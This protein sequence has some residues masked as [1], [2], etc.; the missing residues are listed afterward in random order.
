M[1]KTPLTTRRHFTYRVGWIW[2]CIKRPHSKRIFVKNIEVCVV[3]KEGN[4]EQLVHEE[5]T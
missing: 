4:L 2:H 3:L 1:K 5:T